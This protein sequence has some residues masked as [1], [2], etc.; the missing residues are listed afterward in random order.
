[1]PL[2]RLWPK[3]PQQAA[4]GCRPC[5]SDEQHPPQA[6]VTRFRHPEQ[7]RGRGSG[8]ARTALLLRGCLRPSKLL[9]PRRRR[10]SFDQIAEAA[11]EAERGKPPR[12]P[13]DGKVTGL[14]HVSLPAIPAR[15]R[16][17]TLPIPVRGP[18][19]PALM[20]HRSPDVDLRILP[21]KF[22]RRPLQII[23]P[24]CAQLVYDGTP[25]IR[26]QTVQRK[27]N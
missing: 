7:Q 6:T 19:I 25:A 22:L 24:S 10:W 21:L 4:S 20:S 26:A 9:K 8:S 2:L 16:H 18:Q 15:A 13:Q 14:R 17:C 3:P 12:R 27:K 11:R 1:M 5:Q 23:S